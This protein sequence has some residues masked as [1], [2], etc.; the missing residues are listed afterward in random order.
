MNSM[1]SIILTTN[2][3]ARSFDLIRIA[4]LRLTMKNMFFRQ[5]YSDRSLRIGTYFLFLNLCYLFVSLRW[6]STLLVLGPVLLGYPHL[7]ASYRFLQKPF[8]KIKLFKI[9]LLLTLVSMLIRFLAIPLKVLPQL[10]YGSYEITLSFFAL[11]LSKIRQNWTIKTL[12]L[13]LLL[14]IL[15]TAWNNPLTFVGFALILHNWV[16]FGHWI[17]SARLKRDL[18][19]ALISTLIFALIHILVFS[20]FFDSWI[21][22]ESTNFLSEKSFE[23]KGWVLAP[24]SNSSIVWGR[25]LVLYTFG[26]SIHYFV[27]LQAIPQCLDQNHVPNSFRRTLELLKKDCGPRTTTVLLF[28]ALAILGVWIFTDYAGRIYFGIAMMHGWLELTFLIAAICSFPFKS[29][30]FN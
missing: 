27:W 11:S 21:N 10:P 7:V 13:I 9:F 28:G 1:Q 26:L 24:W 5:I 2:Q 8:E 6:S 14:G 15:K 17:A 29:H 25:A 18:H 20:G 16:A 23:V 30:Q 4:W 22:L 19:V 12:T 3:F